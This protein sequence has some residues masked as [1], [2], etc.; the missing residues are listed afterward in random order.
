M[1]KKIEL[2]NLFDLDEMAEEFVHSFGM[3]SDLEHDD[4]VGFFLRVDELLGDWDFTEK[5]ASKFA[6]ELSKRPAN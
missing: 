1:A 6:R 4:L 2:S 3:S 5:V